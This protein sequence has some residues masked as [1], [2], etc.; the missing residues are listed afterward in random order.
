MA[1][2]LPKAFTIRLLC[3]MS[4]E[5]SSVMLTADE[6]T[7][8]KVTPDTLHEHLGPCIPGVDHGASRSI[9]GGNALA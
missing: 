5:N 3:R 4:M 9:G 1:F 2:A 6:L 7:S 8:A